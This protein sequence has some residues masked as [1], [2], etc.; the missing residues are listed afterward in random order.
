V[1][2]PLPIYKS[3]ICIA[4]P[5]EIDNPCSPKEVE[6]NSQSSQISLPSIIP[7][8]RNLEAFEALSISSRLF[9]MMLP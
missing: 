2:S 8:E 9:M 4:S 1:S 6:N 3:E 5:L 7:T